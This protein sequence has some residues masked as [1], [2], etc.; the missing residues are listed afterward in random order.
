MSVQIRGNGGVVAEVDGTTYRAQR[1]ATR[2]LDHGALGHYHVAMRTG[3][4]PAALI[5]TAQ[6]FSY[7]W[8]HA[9]NLAIITKLQFEFITLAAFTAHQEVSFEAFV[10]RT[11]TT[12]PSAGTA[13]TIT[14]NAFKKR[15]SMATTSVADIRI[16]A[17]AALTAGTVTLDAQPFAV[18]I[19]TPNI[20]NVA[21]GTAFAPYKTPAALW[22]AN[23]ADGEHPIVL[24]QNEGI[25]I[26]NAIVFPAAG[27]G[28]LAVRMDWTEVTAY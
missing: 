27:T 4:L 11:Y 9:T 24:S 7:R 5:A 21:A 10:G 8:S 19:G 3:T 13:A 15:V 2:P 25:I 22:K 16:A 6:L 14:G 28:V 18:A 26:R 12:N 20:N 1:F 17:A 23:V